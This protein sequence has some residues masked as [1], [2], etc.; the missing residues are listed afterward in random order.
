MT[1]GKLVPGWVDR[2]AAEMRANGATVDP[3]AVHAAYPTPVPVKRP[4]L[5][6]KMKAGQPADKSGKRG[7][8]R[9]GVARAAEQ[10]LARALGDDADD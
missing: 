5:W 8:L 7:S 4:A 10:A 2:Y 6:G 9:G 1:D 3:R